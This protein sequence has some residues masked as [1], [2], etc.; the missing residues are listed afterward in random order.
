MDEFGS[1]RSE[2]KPEE[3]RRTKGQ[4]FRGVS[5]SVLT[6]AARLKRFVRLT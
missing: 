5:V 3:R 6:M 4:R 2:R 1:A